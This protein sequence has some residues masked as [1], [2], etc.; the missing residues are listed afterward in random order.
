VGDP[1]TT[2][3]EA[4]EHLGTDTAEAAFTRL[5]LLTFR[6]NGLLVDAGDRLAAPAGLS[7]ARWQV[8]GVV[9]HGPL[10]VA[11]IARRMGL[12]RQS[13]QRTAD[14]LVA[15]GAA[16]F[17]DNPGD[18]RAKLLAPTAS[19]RRALRLTERAQRVWASD[20]GT[21][22]GTDTLEEAERALE[23]VVRALELRRG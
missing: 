2:P 12:R 18:R 10:T 4:H 15:D 19:G 11:A 21:A 22:V 14:A 20:V 13:V 16:A 17:V 9:D 5:A 6:L 7:T 3:G 1:D 23:Q 8:L